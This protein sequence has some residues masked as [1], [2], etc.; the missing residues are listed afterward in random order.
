MTFVDVTC[1]L[2]QTALLF[3]VSLPYIFRVWFIFSSSCICLWSLCSCEHLLNGSSEKRACSVWAVSLASIS[4]FKT[5]SRASVLDVPFCFFFFF[6]SI[7]LSLIFISC[8]FVTQQAL[9]S[10]SM[11]SSFETFSFHE[12]IACRFNVKDQHYWD[13][14][15]LF[16]VSGGCNCIWWQI[17][18]DF[19]V[20][21][22]NLESHSTIL[23]R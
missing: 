6:K 9:W 1:L 23:L 10:P 20:F 18:T 17:A 16:S 22:A 12:Q 3:L 2:F 14:S 4:F 11:W 13:I 8:N 15:L 5:V 7:A 19:G 21:S